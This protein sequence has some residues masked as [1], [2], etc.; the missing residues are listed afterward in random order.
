[1]FDAKRAFSTMSGKV[2]YSSL[3]KQLAQL[4]WDHRVDLPPGFGAE[5]MLEVALE[6]GWLQRAGDGYEISVPES[7]VV[8]SD[9][10]Q[11]QPE[12]PGDLKR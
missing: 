5:E 4:A 11:T 3:R 6:H 1:M 10:S 9:R 8:R 12:R 2:D 7:G